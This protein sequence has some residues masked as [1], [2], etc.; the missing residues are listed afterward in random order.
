MNLIGVADL[1]SQ[2]QIS[3]C[4]SEFLLRTLEVVPSMEGVP[5]QLPQLWWSL[6]WSNLSSQLARGVQS[7]P[8]SH[9]LT[10]AF[11]QERPNWKYITGHSLKML[12]SVTALPSETVGTPNNEFFSTL[13]ASCDRPSCSLLC[14]LC[15]FRSSLENN[16]STDAYNLGARGY[17]FK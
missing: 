2:K 15:G 5:S 7:P 9:S 17:G 10:K 12:V 1:R 13:F 4:A 8:L 16:Y 3:R 14:W 6:S 11:L